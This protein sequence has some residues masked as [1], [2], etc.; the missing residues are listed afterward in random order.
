MSLE[1]QISLMTVPQEFARLCNA[2]LRAEHG[3]DFLPID[4]DQPDAGND[5]YL[6]SQRRMYAMHC[7][8][9]GRR[10]G[11]D[12]SWRGPGDLAATV[13]EHPHLRDLFPI[14]QV[15]EVS[16]RLG[17]LHERVAELAH[18]ADPSRED[19]VGVPRTPDEQARLI[20]SRPPAWEHLLFAG[21]L[22]Q[23]LTRSSSPISTSRWRWERGRWRSASASDST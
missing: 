12:I 3:D 10:A 23:G 15:N 16:D 18:E 1:T 2:A 21:A 5:G 13:Q 4:D 7:F 22:V 19:F 17:E 11:I 8:S 20:A 14:L 6:K 9:I